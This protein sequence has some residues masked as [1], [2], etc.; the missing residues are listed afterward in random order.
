MVAV[1]PFVWIDGLYGRK[2][3]ALYAKHLIWDRFGEE[4]EEGEEVGGE[5][6]GGGW[7]WKGGGGGKV[8]SDTGKWREWE[9]TGDS[10][11]VTPSSPS[12]QTQQPQRRRRPPS[13]YLPMV[14]GSYYSNLDLQPHIFETASLAYRG[15]AFQNI[16][17][18][19]TILV[20]GESGAGKTETVKIVMTDLATMEQTR[21]NKGGDSGGEWEGG[22]VDLD[23]DVRELEEGPRSI[24]RRV[25][26]SNPVFEA[27]GNAQVGAIIGVCGDG[28]DDGFF[29]FF[30][31]CCFLLGRKFL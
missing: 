12:S 27:F 10:G 30:G 5:G 31:Y 9:E 19:Q 15:L 26:E 21:P 6:S 14:Y 20:S 24:V 4:E 13:H 29:C 11:D 28:N 8:Q 7:W 16:R 1:N 3:Q 17:Q 23:V 18:D 22:D 25:L 2:R